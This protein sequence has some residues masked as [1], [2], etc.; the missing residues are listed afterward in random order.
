MADDHAVPADRTVASPAPRGPDVGDDFPTEA[1]LPRRAGD[2]RPARSPAPPTGAATDF[3][4]EFPSEKDAPYSEPARAATAVPR[5]ALP[6]PRTRAGWQHQPAWW[7]AAAC[8]VLAIVEAG[9]ITGRIP[10]KLG[11]RFGGA[12]P[13]SR[14]SAQ[15]VSDGRPGGDPARSGLASAPPNLPPGTTPPVPASALGSNTL[16]QLEVTSDPPGARVTVDDR[17][18]GT[19]P[20]TV[21]V[22]PGPHIVIVSDGT[23]SSR[24]TVDTVAGGTATFLASFAPVAMSAGWVSIRSPLELQIREGDSLLGATTAD[25]LMMPSGRHVLAL[26]NAG[27]AFQTTL[28]VTVDPGKT[29]TSTV[30]IPNGSLSLNALPWA[31]VTIDGQALSGTTPFANLQVPLGPHEIGWT[32]PQFGE[33][34]Q[35]VVVNAKTPVRLVVDLRVK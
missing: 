19:T 31:S 17:V 3:S 24:K 5:V 33:R 28:T 9:V 14:Q 34:H 23:A 25:R 15:A 13:A 22:S 16:S 6:P 27:A 32:N 10:L 29:T 21:P 11:S 12:G 26:S 4:S 18:R 2:A 20:V 30:T 35:T 7:I 8:A 1:S